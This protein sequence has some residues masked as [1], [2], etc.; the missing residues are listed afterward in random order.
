MVVIRL[1]R[2]GC[3]ARPYYR[4]VVADSRKSRDGRN[5]EEV[6]HYHPLEGEKG[7]VSIKEDRIK[8]WLSVGAKAS[9]TVRSILKRQG[10][11]AAK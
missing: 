9:V 6:G 1:K 3:K 10:V 4:L 2:M 8:Y 11:L 7:A 5:I